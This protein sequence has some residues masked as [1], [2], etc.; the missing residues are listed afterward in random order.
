MLSCHD[1]DF[2]QR[3]L[4]FRPPL[5]P[6]VW[7]MTL[8]APPPTNAAGLP[9]QLSI[10]SKPRRSPPRPGLSARGGDELLGSDRGASE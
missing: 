10:V 6:P 5:S 9:D 1:T 2:F 3:R 8:A 7:Q 4:T